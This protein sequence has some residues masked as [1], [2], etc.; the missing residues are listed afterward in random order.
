MEQ[1]LFV[2]TA[3]FGQLYGLSKS[4]N[5][6]SQDEINCILN[7]MADSLDIRID[8]SPSYGNSENVIGKFNTDSP[9]TK[10]KV[11][12]KIPQAAYADPH[13]ILESVKGSLIAI[14]I[15]SFESVLLHGLNPEFKS[16][17]KAISEGLQYILAEGLTLNIGLSC[18]SKDEVLLAKELIPELSVFQVPENVLDQ[19]LLK[20]KELL[21]LQKDGN[22]F[23]VRSIFLQGLLLQDFSNLPTSFDRLKPF[24]MDL[25]I[26]AIQNNISIIEYCVA[27]TKSIP[28]ASGF[29]VGI[30][31]LAQLKQLVSQFSCDYS[32]ITFTNNPISNELVDPRNWNS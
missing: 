27:Y 15:Q 16:Q 6:I 12:T 1:L 9:K 23:I 20:S 2:G 5:G 29:V 26:S 8:T 22:Q 30:D 31:S 28:W 11:T 4:K 7:S 32:Q 18:Y 10:N 13:Q 24:L 25:E 17:Y 21:M 14:G 19:R 3:N